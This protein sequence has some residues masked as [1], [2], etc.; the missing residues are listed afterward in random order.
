MVCVQGRIRVMVV[1][2]GIDVPVKD[3]EVMEY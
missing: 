1:F 2:R 3:W